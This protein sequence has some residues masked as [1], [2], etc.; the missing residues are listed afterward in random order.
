MSTLLLINVG[1]SCSY[2]VIMR[3][4]YSLFPSGN[5]DKAININE[6]VYIKYD[7]CDTL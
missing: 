6:L 1:V 4:T 5:F 7:I 2:I 3:T